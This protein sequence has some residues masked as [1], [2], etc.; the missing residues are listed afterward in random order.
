MTTDLP[1]AIGE[2]AAALARVAS[3]VREDQL[4]ARTPC[5]KFSA[6]E[7]LAHLGEV[8]PASERAAHK[9]PQPAAGSAPEPDDPAAIAAAARR[10]AVAWSDPAAYED[11]TEFGPGGMPAAVAAI[12]TLQELAV[13]GWDLA[14]ATG[15][16]FEVGEAAGRAALEAV[17]QIAGNAR[18]SGAYGP[19]FDVPA[20]APAFHRA[21]ADSGR[22]PDWAG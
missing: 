16:P 10:V 20:T 14:R 18:V 15:Q 5:E 11:T 22:N 1:A 8:L 21:L 3:S 12:I 13:H 9:V 6:A 7:L 19:P 17:D 2:F 4:A